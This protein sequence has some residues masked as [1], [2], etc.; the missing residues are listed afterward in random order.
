M[1]STFLLAAAGA[2]AAAGPATA[3][4]AVDVPAFDS[5]ELRGGGTVTIRHGASQ[6]VTL[7]SGNLETSRFTVGDEGRLTIRACASTC[8][9][10]ALRVEIVTPELNGVGISGGGSL[11]AEGPFPPQD[12]LA[13]GINGGGTI[14]LSAIDAGNVAAGIEGG[15]SIRTHARHTLVAG[16]NGG[17]TIRYEG[18]PSVTSGINGGG[19][20]SPVRPR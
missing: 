14:D 15:G 3:Q 4:T 1:K 9:D 20:V 2:L 19:T 18:S 11:R 8:R 6:S 17:G 13:I 16:I 12:E 5:V 10:Y 7:L